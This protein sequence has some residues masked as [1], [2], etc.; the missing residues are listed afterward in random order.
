MNIHL[1]VS[2]NNTGLKIQLLF[3][4]QR[5]M[6]KKK[7]DKNQEFDVMFSAWVYKLYNISQST[8]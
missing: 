7:Q 8:S 2:H 4:K 3:S 1:P 5:N 6:L